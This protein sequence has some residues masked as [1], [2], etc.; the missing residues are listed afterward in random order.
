MARPI[1]DILD[2]IR[3]Q[4]LWRTLRRVDGPTGAE[5]VFEG[6]R[7]V[8]LCSNNY[9][10]LAEHPV[11]REGAIRA[12]ERYGAGSGGSRLIGGS[13]AIHHDLEEAIAAFKG[14]E[15]ALLFN[16]G[17]HANIGII[18]TLV[19]RDDI[20]YS[21]EWNHASLIDGCRLSRARLRVY[22]HA[23]VAH[24]AELLESDR[25]DAG[26]KLIVTDSVFSMDG[27]VAPLPEIVA[28]AE[29][30]DALVMVDEAHGTGVMGP[31]GR[32][33]VAHFD[34]Q[35][36]VAVQMGTLGKALGSFGAYVA[37]SRELIDLMI[38]RS[39]TFIFTTA[40]PPAASGAALAA[41]GLLESDD[42]LVDALWQNTAV[43]RSRLRRGGIEVLGNTPIVPIV[44]GEPEATVEAFQRLLDEGYHIQAI[45]PP[46]VAPGTSRLRATVTAAHSEEQLRQ[47]A[48]V[49]IRTLSGR[50]Q[51]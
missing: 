33:V 7:V 10:G 43:F 20:V 2:G 41:L 11:V 30:N 50:M 46:T 24:L 36:R 14:T 35:G 34:L 44:I 25:E 9:L 5:Y 40:L 27:D 47:A 38:N 16:S 4:G 12:V 19:G 23:D 13:L 32:G 29:S 39:R 51:A 49:V 17:Y 31:G 28:L 15:A 26:R 37:G 3:R 42:S 21:D 18:S 45:R 6:R 1:R 8:G 48:E 22:R